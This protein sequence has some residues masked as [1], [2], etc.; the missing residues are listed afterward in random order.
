MYDVVKIIPPDLIQEVVEYGDT[1][2]LY[3][4]GVTAKGKDLYDPSMRK[5]MAV[6]IDPRLFPEVV[7]IIETHINDGTSVNQFDFLIYQPGDYFK[8]HKD[9]FRESRLEDY[10][11][12]STVTMLDKSDD[13]EGGAL[14]ID[15]CDPI[16]LDIGETVIFKSDLVHEAQQVIC[17]TRK[18]LV[19]W[20]GLHKF[21]DIN[22]V[23]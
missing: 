23:D 18:V 21:N 13:L 2:R 3:R 20:L 6:R 4:T 1:A 12:W 19:A 14:H 10:R 9:T 11:I 5:T 16:N 22:I 15:G 7:D 17:G 8:P